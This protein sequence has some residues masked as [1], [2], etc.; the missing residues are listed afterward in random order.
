[1]IEDCGVF[2]F[3]ILLVR[4]APGPHAPRLS[5]A[6]NYLIQE[7][8]CLLLNHKVIDIKSKGAAVT[9]TGPIPVTGE[10]YPYNAA[11]RQYLP[12]DLAS[13][14]YVEEEFLVSGLANV[15]E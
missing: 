9:V 5:P 2:D 10:S 14:G 7:R 11:N 1:M 15:Y 3:I 13:R 4:T 8:K 12:L 6:V